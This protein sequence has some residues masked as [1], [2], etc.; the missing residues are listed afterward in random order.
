MY[1]VCIM[2]I[3]T[4]VL[5]RDEERITQSNLLV[6]DKISQQRRRVSFLQ[7]KINSMFVSCSALNSMCQLRG[8][9]VLLTL[10]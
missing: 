9:S 5:S 8:Q 1:Y 7:P 2:Y 10:Y 3:A 4:D 6:A